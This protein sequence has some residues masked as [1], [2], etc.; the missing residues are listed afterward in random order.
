MEEQKSCKQFGYLLLELII[1]LNDLDID[2]NLFTYLLFE[3]GIVYYQDILWSLPNFKSIEK[4]LVGLPTLFITQ[5]ICNMFLLLV[6]V[7]V[8]LWTANRQT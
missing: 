1:N 2:H 8:L 3:M 6:S 4:R 5:L 7:F